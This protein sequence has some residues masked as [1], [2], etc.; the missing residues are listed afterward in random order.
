MHF[1]VQRWGADSG[2]EL[3]I[4]HMMAVKVLMLCPPDVTCAWKHSVGLSP[5]LTDQHFSLQSPGK[6]WFICAAVIVSV[7]VKNICRN[8][9]S[10]FTCVEKKISVHTSNK[11]P[12]VALILF[13]V[14][15]VPPGWGHYMELEKVFDFLI[16]CIFHLSFPIWK[17]SNNYLLMT[18]F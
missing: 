1:A 4:G 3:I 11:H 18:Y 12:A 14:S 5:I 17:K 13:P 6:Q 16:F 2:K 8:C 10:V 15:T 7:R 9:Q